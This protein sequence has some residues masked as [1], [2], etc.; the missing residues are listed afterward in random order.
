MGHKKSEAQEGACPTRQEVFDFY[1]KTNT[2]SKIVK[3]MENR[4][5]AVWKSN[6]LC[7]HVMFIK[8]SQPEIEEVLAEISGEGPGSW[9]IDTEGRLLDGMS[10]R[11]EDASGSGY[12]VLAISEKPG[13]EGI[14][15][16]AHEAVHTAV[17]ILNDRKMP[18]DVGDGPDSHSEPMAYLV[19]SL[20]EFGIRKL[21]PELKLSQVL[22]PVDTKTLMY[23]HKNRPEKSKVVE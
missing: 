3:L 11:A 7:A 18:L 13:Y 19:G 15:I 17:K 6:E 20:V 8:A 23:Y 12:Y 10:F 4:C 2:D 14:P 5:L 16:L 22:D 9:K 21:Y 1:K